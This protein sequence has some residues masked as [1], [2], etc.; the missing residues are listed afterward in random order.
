MPS[1]SSLI[2]ESPWPSVQFK[3]IYAILKA[4]LVLGTYT[5]S[6]KKQKIQII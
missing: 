5:L 3:K 1:G 2:K 6:K 4:K